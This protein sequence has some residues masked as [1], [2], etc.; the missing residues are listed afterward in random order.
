MLRSGIAG[1]YG[2]SIF[3]FLRDLHTVL[4]SG[5]TNLHSHH[6]CRRVPF[7]PHPLQY[8]LFVDFLMMAVETGVRWYFIVV[9]FVFL[10]YLVMLSICSC[11]SWPSVCLLWR[12]VYFDLLRLSCECSI[13]TI[14]KLR[15]FSIVLNRFQYIHAFMK[16][17]QFGT[18][19][20]QMQFISAFNIPQWL[21]A[22][23]LLHLQIFSPILRVVFWSCLRF[24][25]LCKSF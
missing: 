23:L 20:W 15:F 7:S 22:L 12:N 18:L 1:A 11:A 9:W 5:C 16:R 13:F 19:K 6:Q 24:P 3:S 4:H 25:L 10:Y 8:L 2:K 21:S 14:A 17:K